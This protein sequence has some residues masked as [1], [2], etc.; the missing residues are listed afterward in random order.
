MSVIEIR[1]RF[2]QFIPLP[3][4]ELR[5]RLAAALQHPEAEIRGVVYEHYALLTIPHEKRHFWSPQMNLSIEPTPDGTTVRGLI[6]PHPTVWL[7]FT[8]IYALLAF[9][10]LIVLITGF[11]RVN[12]GLAAPELWVL[13]FTGGLALALYFAAKTGE[14]LGRQ[15]MEALYHFLG[16]ALWGEGGVASDELRVGSYE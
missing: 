14:R 5:E 15:E 8:F 11:S 9:I 4:A 13:P 7:M 3:S 6:G 12:L 1:P 16:K 10:S 2:E